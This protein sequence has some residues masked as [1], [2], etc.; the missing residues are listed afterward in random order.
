MAESEARDFQLLDFF[1]FFFLR[2]HS[3]LYSC[4]GPLSLPSIRPWNHFQPRPLPTKRISIIWRSFTN[5]ALKYWVSNQS[6]LGFFLQTTVLFPACY[7]MILFYKCQTKSLD[8]MN[9]RVKTILHNQLLSKVDCGVPYCKRRL[10]IKGNFL[11]KW[12]S[13]L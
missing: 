7:M 1:F 5:T 4:S 11:I 6:R 13:F 10:N 9:I 8:E 3:I 12:D 2:L